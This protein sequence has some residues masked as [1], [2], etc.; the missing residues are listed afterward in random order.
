MSIYRILRAT[1]LALSLAVCPLLKAADVSVPDD[2][3][4]S[5]FSDKTLTPCVASLGVAASGAVYVGVDQI[6]S[7]GKGG[8]KGRI[9]RLVDADRDGVMDSHT[10]FAVVD[11]PRG[12]IPMGNK[13]YVLHSKWGEGKKYEGAFIT[14]FT[15]ADNDGVADGPGITIVREISSRKFNQ[16]RGV[17][18]TTNGIRMG[19]DGWIYIAIGDFGF[20]N[21]VGRDGRTLTCYGGGVVRVRPDGSEMEMYVHGLRNIYD[22]AIDPRMNMFTRGNTNDGGGW[23]IRFI[24]EIQTGEYGYPVLFKRFTNEIIP[25]L[26]DVGGGSGTGSMFFSEPGWPARYTNVPMMCDWGRQQLFIHRVTPDG[27]SFTQEEEAFIA[28]TKISDVDCDA[29]G[30]LYLGS[31]NSGYTGGDGG[32]V[33]RVVPKDWTYK[34]IPDLQKASPLDLAELHASPSAKLRLAAQ[35]ALLEN[36]KGKTAEKSLYEMAADKSAL[37]DSRVAAV[38]T[39]K[40]LVG[41]ESHKVLLKLS[42]DASIRE[43]ALRAIADRASQLEGVSPDAFV[44]ALKDNNPRVQVV[45]AV[46]LGRLGDASAAPSLLAVTPVP[47]VAPSEAKVA[48]YEGYRSGIVEGSAIRLVDFDVRKLKDLYL[49]IGEGDN[50]KGTDHGSWFEPVLVK[51]DGSELKLSELPWVSAKGGWGK[52][53]VNKACTGAA[54]QREDGKPVAFGIGSHAPSVIHYKLPPGVVRFKASVGNSKGGGGAMEFFVNGTGLLPGATKANAAGPHA[55]PNAAIILPHVAVNALVALDAA[56]AC[57]AAIDGPNRAGALWALQSMYSDRTVDGLIEKLE[58][59][60]DAKTRQDVAKAL[61]RLIH[62]EKPYE[63]DTWWGTRPDTRGPFYYPTTWTRSDAIKAALV[64][65]YEAGDDA[66]RN[67]IATY[68]E[69][70]RAPIAGLNKESAAAPPA[71]KK[72]PKVNLNKIT[73]ADG[74]VGKMGLEDVL[75][76]LNEVKGDPSRGKGLFTQQGCIACHTL[77]KTETPKGPYMG[78]VGAIMNREQIAMAILRPNAEISQG[79]KTVMITMNDGQVHVG[80]VTERLNDQVEIRDIAGQVTRLRPEDIKTE[81]LLEKSMMPEGLAN[82]MSLEDFVSLVKFLES[83]KK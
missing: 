81:V 21:A 15:D 66:M 50:G 56:E 80:F 55:T 24:H 18:H 22:V 1:T 10:V 79:F 32:F 65:A 48:S 54:L 31:F 46:A 76:A 30:Q 3:T 67:V 14:M 4:F 38:F 13:L 77:D 51:N 28:C 57:L 37:H 23:N 42:Q 49:L 7:L 75:I 26:V 62:H 5:I 83:K 44:A 39:L 20:A 17:D 53:L 61:V 36:P 27:A 41:V 52:T 47:D 9:I 12:I 19:I 63:G 58:S 29:S 60:S 33:A 40:Q 74:Q 8:G 59:A 73:N 78:Q 71:K 68:T 70:D 16:S 25:A 43:H 72:Q 11:N 34:A 64:K 69:K 45:A 35:Q 6:G 2:L 82:G